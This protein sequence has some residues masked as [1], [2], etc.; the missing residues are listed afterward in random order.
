MINS[1]VNVKAKEFMDDAGST[2]SKNIYSIATQPIQAILTIAPPAAR[3]EFFQKI[4]APQVVAG[5][6]TL[7]VNRLLADGIAGIKAGKVTASQVTEGIAD[8]GAAAVYTNNAVRDYNAFGM[9]TQKTAIVS[10]SVPGTVFGTNIERI[11]ITNTTDI[12]RVLTKLM[13]AQRIIELRKGVPLVTPEQ[14]PFNFFNDPD[15]I[16]LEPY[17][18]KGLPSTYP[19]FNPPWKKD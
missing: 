13:A 16:E 17:K 2:D 8:L 9:P 14:N 6:K 18:S 5:M 15:K 3:T 10:I 1:E 4:V 7:D 11:R 19:S 12:N